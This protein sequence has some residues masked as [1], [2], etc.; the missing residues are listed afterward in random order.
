MSKMFFQNPEVKPLYLASLSAK[1]LGCARVPPPQASPPS[2]P[3][4]AGI[5]MGRGVSGGER[6]EE[7][8]VK[9]RERTIAVSQDPS[10]AEKR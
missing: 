5:P 8:S 10:S 9:L 6:E 1:A 2:P 3:F 7:R 4:Q